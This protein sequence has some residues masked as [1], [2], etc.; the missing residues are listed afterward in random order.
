[1]KLPKTL[2]QAITLSVAI[3]AVAGITTSCEKENI[4]R[5][6]AEPTDDGD[7]KPQ[8]GFDDDCPACGMG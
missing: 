3:T 4:D 7:P 8:C 5:T 1:M 6:T 2:L